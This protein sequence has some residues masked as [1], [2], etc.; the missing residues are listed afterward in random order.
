MAHAGRSSVFLLRPPRSPS[1]WSDAA[2]CHQPEFNRPA[3]DTDNSLVGCPRPC[4][5]LSTPVC[6][7]VHGRVQRVAWHLVTEMSFAFIILCFHKKRLQRCES[8]VCEWQSA[9]S[10]LE[11]HFPLIKRLLL[12]SLLS[13][14][15]VAWTSC[16]WNNCSIFRFQAFIYLNFL[17]QHLLIPYHYQNAFVVFKFNKYCIRGGN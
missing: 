17:P 12:F 4:A 13:S 15:V 14:L 6:N 1:P 5:T 11:Y 7:V 3:A 9:V 2:R 16:S 10:F 8:V